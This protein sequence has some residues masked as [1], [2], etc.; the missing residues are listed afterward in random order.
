MSQQEQGLEITVEPA[1][2]RVVQLTVQVPPE[3][4]LGEMKKTA[5]RIARETRIP[6]FR[7]GKAP[8]EIVV[9]RYGEEMIRAEAVEAMAE[10]IYR[11]AIEQAEIDPYAAGSLTDLLLDPLRFVFT[12]PLPPVVDLGDYR[13]LR[14]PRPQVKVDKKE[15]K[16]ALEQ[17]RQEHAVLEPAGDRGA[18]PGDALEIKVEGRGEDGSLFVDQEIEIVL[19]PKSTQPVPGFH[20]ELRGIKVDEKRTFRLAMPN[21]QPSPEADFTVQLLRLSNRILPG[22]DDD[23]ARTVGNFDRLKELEQDIRERLQEQKQER[24]NDEYIQQVVDRVLA[25]ASVEYPPAML[26]EEIDELVEEFA[27]RVK[28]ELRMSLEAYLTATDKSEESLRDELSE[29]AAQHLLQS[30][31]FGQIA[32]QEGLKASKEEIAEL[33]AE[34]AAEQG[35]GEEQVRTQLDTPE[36]RQVLANSILLN[37]IF[38]RLIAIA[39][40]QAEPLEEVG[41]D[42]EQ[43]PDPNGD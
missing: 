41:D 18:Q 39:L 27:R 19:N 34:I 2:M 25:G 37:K 12:I 10:S 4:V 35:S 16:E 23:L 14:V 9:Q 13:S 42:R 26:E 40:G 38:D 29:Q 31:V 21:G 36:T 20:Q 30:L 22:I 33:I 5:R 15:I 24:V 7:K 32:H 1:G 8:Y 17:L 28:R 6:G 43:E 3:R 11:E